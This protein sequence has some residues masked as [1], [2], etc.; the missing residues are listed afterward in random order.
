MKLK[1]IFIL[2]FM[3]L[4]FVSAQAQVTIGTDESPDPG[5]LLQLKTILNITDDS[6]NAKQGLLL[7]RVTL[8]SLT[9]SSGSNMATTINGTSASDD[10]DK[11][12]HV[13]LVV[14]HIKGST[15][16]ETGIYVWNRKTVDGNDVYQWLPVL[17]TP[18]L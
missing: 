1:H 3:F 18:P 11:D 9:I 2:I 16:I 10:W 12:K 7:S 6:P 8:N 5:M 15:S 14:Y 13:G 4:A 17:Q